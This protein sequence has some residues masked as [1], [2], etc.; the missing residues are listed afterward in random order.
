MRVSLEESGFAGA[1]RKILTAANKNI[2]FPL[3]PR[4]AKSYLDF[5]AHRKAELISRRKYV[6]TFANELGGEVTW[7]SMG[8]SVAV[9]SMVA[10]LREAVESGRP[11]VYTG[12]EAS[13]LLE[14]MSN[15]DKVDSLLLELQRIGG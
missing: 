15:M 8:D 6:E 12:R 2:I 1:Q 14:Y 10:K 13:A 3:L 7:D 11:V 4:E 5:M 9:A